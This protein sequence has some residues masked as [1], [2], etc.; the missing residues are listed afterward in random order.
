MN[1]LKKKILNNEDVH[2]KTKNDALQLIEKKFSN[3]SQE[4]AGSRSAEGWHFDFHPINGS[5]NSIE[6]INIYSKYLKFRVHITWG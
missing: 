1:R 5:T 3:F 2:V 6:H 4:V